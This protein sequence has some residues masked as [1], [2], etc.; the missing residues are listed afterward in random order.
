[1]LKHSIRFK[2][3]GVFFII[4][5]FMLISICIINSFGLEMFYRMEK[6]KEIQNAYESINTKVMDILYGRDGSDAQSRDLKNSKEISKSVQDED[7]DE[8]ETNQDEKNTTIVYSKKLSE[9][10]VEYS[11]RYNISIIV[12][13]P[14]D[15]TLVSTE[16]YG[17]AVC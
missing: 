9:I 6:V 12:V 5:V 2:L 17:E 13:D 1:M 11:N 7:E 8:Q 3:T 10:L 16:R 14:N 15:K 4:I